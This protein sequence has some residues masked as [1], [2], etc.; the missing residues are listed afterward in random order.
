MFDRDGMGL[1]IWV[2]GSI[3]LLR[4]GLGSDRVLKNFLSSFTSLMLRIELTPSLGEITKQMPRRSHLKVRGLCQELS[5][6]GIMNWAYILQAF[7]Q[8]RAFDPGLV[9]I[10]A[11]V[12]E[13]CSYGIK[14][15]NH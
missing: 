3:R 13:A 4:S 9:F 1:K 11:V 12:F 7:L 6:G 8:A 5:P 15:F 14:N 10:A 2:S